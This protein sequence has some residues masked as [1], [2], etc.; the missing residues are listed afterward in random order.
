MAEVAPTIQAVDHFLLGAT[1]GVTSDNETPFQSFASRFGGDGNYLCSQ[2][3]DTGINYDNEADFCGGATPDIVTS[4]GTLLSTFGVVANAKQP[5]KLEISF[6]AGEGANVKIEGHQHTDNPHTAL[7]TFDCSGLIPALSGVGVPEL[8]AFVGTASP[9]TASLNL[10]IEHV[11]KPGATGFHFEGQNIRCHASLSVDFAAQPT[12]I[13][14]GDWLNV[15]MVKSNPND[16]TPT[17]SVTA[18][19]WIDINAA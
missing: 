16:D 15:I 9:V 5:T 11:D 17:A 4:L 13:T 19:Q 14:A 10:E 12:S 7:N 2:E 1:F 18:E 3:Y 6:E 8:I